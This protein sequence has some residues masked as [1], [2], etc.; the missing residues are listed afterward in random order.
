MISLRYL[1]ASLF[2]AG[3]LTATPLQAQTAASAAPAATTSAAPR[4]ELVKM[5]QMAQELMKAGQPAEALTKLREAD[6]VTNRT[7]REDYLLER[8]RGAAALAAKD[9]ATALAAFTKVL[10]GTELPVA[11]RLGMMEA[12]AGLAYR[13]E[14]NKTTERWAR[15]Y[16]A[17]GGKSEGVRTL[18]IHTLYARNE[19]PAMLKELNVAIAED[20]AAGR[21]V[22]ETKYQLLAQ[23]S[24]K[25]GDTATFQKALEKLVVMKPKA[26]YWNALIGNLQRQPGFAPRLGLDV[27]RLARQVGVLAEADEWMDL[28][29]SAAQ[30]G[31]PIEASAA[32]E[33]G[34]RKGVLGQGAGAAAQTKLRAQL[35]KAAAED[36]S[37]LKAGTASAA[38]AK[39]G[40]QLAALGLALVS[41]GQAEAGLGLMAQGIAKGIAKFPDDAQ[42]RYGVALL[43][44]GQRDKAVEVLQAL[45]GSDGSA[46]LARLWL[47]A[48]R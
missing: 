36:R 12:M 21:A 3:V 17:E 40:G 46:D 32:L 43:T 19:F 25:V 29:Q 33:E 39:D 30:A 5:L 7:A 45:K 26:E 8:T 18:L 9:N 11:E 38:K 2:M 15:Q 4:A 41:D 44:S 37:Q 35:A 27:L 24:Q 47:L 13:A 10:D 14:D 1:T 48:V 6:A 20:E 28:A 31:Q 16:F 22:N 34:W 42:L 23:G